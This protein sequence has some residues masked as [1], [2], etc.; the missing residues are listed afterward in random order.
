MDLLEEKPRCEL[1]FRGCRSVMARQ[2]AFYEH[3]FLL[4]QHLGQVVEILEQFH[5]EGL[6][7]PEYV[8]QRIQDVEDLRADL[9]HVVTG[10]LH[11]RELEACVRLVRK[12]KGAEGK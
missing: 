5:R 9:S 11:R 6:I 3:L 4:N 12:E 7:H 8:A 10:M 1:V 2:T